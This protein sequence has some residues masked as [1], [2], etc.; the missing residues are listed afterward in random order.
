M[1][2]TSLSPNRTIRCVITFLMDELRSTTHS[3]IHLFICLFSPPV[4]RPLQ[5][6]HFFHGKVLMISK[7]IE[8]S[9]LFISLGWQHLPCGTC[10]GKGFL[11]CNEGIL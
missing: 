1:C 5:G 6:W 2:D 11:N 3:F 4:A 7:S 8:V 9:S 10:A